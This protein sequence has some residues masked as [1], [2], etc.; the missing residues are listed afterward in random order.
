MLSEVFLI[1]ADYNINLADQ[2]QKFNQICS[3]LQW[4]ISSWEKNNKVI[5]KIVY[6]YP[7]GQRNSVLAD[8]KW[9]ANDNTKI[10]IF[11]ALITKLNI[12]NQALI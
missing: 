9:T 10:N 11:F 12:L 4:S 1:F 3:R 5:T 7:S 2:R 6:R 8:I